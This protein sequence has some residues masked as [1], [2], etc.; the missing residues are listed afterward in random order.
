MFAYVLTWSLDEMNDLFLHSVS[1][2][3]AREGVVDG[4][5]WVYRKKEL[6]SHVTE[7]VAP[8]LEGRKAWLV[9]NPT[10]SHLSRRGIQWDGKHTQETLLPSGALGSTSWTLVILALAVAFSLLVAL[11]MIHTIVHC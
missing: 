11:P 4:W 9:F 3:R 1:G 2:L 8:D 5:V 7:R 6:R 10:P